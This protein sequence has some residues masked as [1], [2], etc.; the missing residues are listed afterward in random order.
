LAGDHLAARQFRETHTICMEI[1]GRDA[2]VADAWYYLGVIAA[3]HQNHAKACELY[4]K[5]IAIGPPA[6]RWHADKARSLVALF[7]RDEARVEAERAIAITPHAARTLDTIGVVFSRLGLHER[8]TPFYRQAT[9]REPGNAAYWYNLGAALQFAGDFIE[10]EAAYLKALAID[11]RDVRA[12][13]ALVLMKR[14]TPVSN[15]R[16]TLEALF[17]TLTDAGERLNIGHALAKTAEDLG[18]VDAAMMWLDRAKAAK[19]AEMGYDIAGTAELFNAATATLSSG[20]RRPGSPDASPIVVVGLPRTGTTLIDRILSQH[21]RIRSAGELSDF[22][23]ELKI[24]TGTASS[25]VLDAETL[26]AGSRVDPLALGEA[27]VARARRVAGDDVPHFIDKMPLNFFFV[28]LILQALPNA[29]IVCVRRHPIDTVLSNYR[30]LFATGYSY[31]GYAHDLRWA[32]DYYMRFDRLIAAYRAALA[33]EH[34]MEVAYEDV[35]ADV[36]AEARRLVAFCDLQWEP[37]CVDF[38]ENAAPVATASSTQVRQPIYSTS[39]DRWRRYRK[40]LQPVI[41]VFEAN[42]IAI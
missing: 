34:F 22:A 10:A 19:R 32:A 36:E 24:R 41:D 33:P 28:P 4:D 2:R 39:V 3:E 6:S 35:V 9:S 7:R 31:Y 20:S 17:A 8:A 18:D 1:L 21:S 5:A 25:F 42:G 38:H 27:Y 26:A 15:H 14:Q 23:L 40:H 16:A 12:W 13:S 11:P 30:Q 37:Q 29:R